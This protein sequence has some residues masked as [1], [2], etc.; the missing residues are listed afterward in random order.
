MLR[1][2][3]NFSLSLTDEVT[4]GIYYF[5]SLIV[6][7]ILLALPL[8]LTLFPL[9]AADKTQYFVQLSFSSNLQSIN[10]IAS[11]LQKL[12]KYFAGTAFDAFFRVSLALFRAGWA[13]VF[14]ANLALYLK[15]LLS[16]ITALKSVAS[17]L[18]QNHKLP[19]ASE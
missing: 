9:Q 7:I 8:L 15:L 13:T 2:F 1:I 3:D 11:D 16:S 12:I 17:S 5:V 14:P 6:K 10:S 4:T 18:E 19:V